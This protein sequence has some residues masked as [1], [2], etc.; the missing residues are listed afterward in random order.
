MEDIGECHG[1]GY[2]RFIERLCQNNLVCTDYARLM[3]KWKNEDSTGD[4]EIIS[5][6]KGVKLWKVFCTGILPRN[7]EISKEIKEIISLGGPTDDNE[8]Y[9]ERLGRYVENTSAVRHGA[10]GKESRLRREVIKKIC[11]TFKR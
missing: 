2:V 6:P 11:G 4:S 3:L 7:E 5:D 8:L 10:E 9:L 1:Q